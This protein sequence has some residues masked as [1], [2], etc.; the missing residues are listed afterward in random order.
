MKYEIT[1]RL[2][3]EALREKLAS[4]SALH[5]FRYYTHKH[6]ALYWAGGATVINI[7][8]TAYFGMEYHP[9]NEITGEI[10]ETIRHTR[11]LHEFLDGRYK[12]LAQPVTNVSHVSMDE[13]RPMSANQARAQVIEKAK[14]FVEKMEKYCADS[15]LRLMYHV[16][17]DKRAVTLLATRGVTKRLVT[18]GVA[19]CAPDDV[20]NLDIGKA[21][22]LGRAFDKDVQEFEQAIQPDEV[23]VGMV[24]TPR[25]GSGFTGGKFE[26]QSLSE[27]MVHDKPIRGFI[28]RDSAIIL[29][30]TYAKYPEEAF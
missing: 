27:D 3:I 4:F 11:P 22:A 16:N 12:L 9:V 10:Y 14:A 23:V 8:G 26:V 15:D 25:E 6:Q 5:G 30:D 19:K 20:F 29:D 17:M 13:V 18:K 7:D 24:V 21:I 2:S 1:E 28:S